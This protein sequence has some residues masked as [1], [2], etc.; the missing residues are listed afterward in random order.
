MVINSLTK[1]TISK[2]FNISIALEYID[3]RTKVIIAVITLAESL[4]IL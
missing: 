1:S 3:S 4:L 2:A